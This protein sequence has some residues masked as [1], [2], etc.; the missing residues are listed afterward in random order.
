MRR[1]LLTVEETFF[2]RGRNILLLAPFL[3]ELNTSQPFKQPTDDLWPDIPRMPSPRPTQVELR[4]PDGT[5]RVVA[6]RFVDTH[7]N[8]GP[9]NWRSDTPPG[10]K[11][12]WVVQCGLPSIS[13]EAIPPGTQIWYDAD[14]S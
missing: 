3:V 12:P 7:F 5:T 1:L 6:C 2:L 14:T 10:F 8:W 13:R 11:P 9:D 4:L